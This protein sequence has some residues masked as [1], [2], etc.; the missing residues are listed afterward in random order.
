MAARAVVRPAGMGA[1]RP[2]RAAGPVWTGPARS[3]VDGLGRFGRWMFAG[4]R[5]DS[6][7]VDHLE[8]V[9]MEQLDGGPAGRGKAD[10]EGH[11]L[12]PGEMVAPALSPR[13]EQRG[14]APGHRIGAIRMVIFMIITYLARQG[15]VV[16]G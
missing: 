7:E 6:P 4:R 3:L 10:D 9:Q 1:P 13:M 14:H 12:I 16:A 15:Q 11:F 2:G 5:E 8:T